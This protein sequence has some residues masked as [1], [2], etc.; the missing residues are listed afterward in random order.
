MG[1]FPKWVDVRPDIVASAGGEEAVA[2]ARRRNQAHIDRYRLSERQ[3]DTRSAQLEVSC[4][5]GDRP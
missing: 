5:L 2:E 3:K 4:A 1:K